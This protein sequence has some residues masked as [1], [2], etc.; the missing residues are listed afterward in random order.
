MGLRAGNGWVGCAQLLAPGTYIVLNWGQ[1]FLIIEVIIYWLSHTVGGMCF[2]TSFYLK[3]CIRLSCSLC[4]QLLYSECLGKVESILKLVKAHSSFHV[5]KN[6]TQ[7]YAYVS[8]T[9]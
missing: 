2:V 3:C 7:I 9:V 6:V 5:L 1:L 4:C 8:S